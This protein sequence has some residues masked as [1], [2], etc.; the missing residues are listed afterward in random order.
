MFHFQRLQ[1][2]FSEENFSELLYAVQLVKVEGGDAKLEYMEVV[3]SYFS[4]L[5]DKLESDRSF[6]FT[7]EVSE[8]SKCTRG[9]CII[10][11]SFQ[12]CSCSRWLLT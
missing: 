3:N 2:P 11:A 9:S 1:H 10:F 4:Q 5:K 8:T 12:P 7:A 6:N